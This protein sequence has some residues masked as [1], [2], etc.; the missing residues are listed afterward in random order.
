MAGDSDSKTVFVAVGLCLVCSMV[1]SVLAVV[2][3][4]IQAEQRE[5]FRKQSIL[6]AAGIW[7]DGADANKLF[8]R[9]REIKLDL[10]DHI[11]MDGDASDPKYDRAKSLR[12]EDLHVVL[13]QADDPAGL[14][15][16][17]K[18]VIIYEVSNDDDEGESQTTRLV[19]PIRGRGLW[20]T[21]YGFIAVDVGNGLG[22]ESV[23]VVGITYYKHGETPGLG[24]E[25]ENPLWK[26][27]WPG[28]K[29]YDQDWK[30]VV[31]VAKNAPQDSPTQVDAISGATLTSNG[32]TNMLQFWLGKKGFGPYVRQ[33]ADGS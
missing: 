5:L 3:R 16:L 15:K 20:S 33:I 29:V 22:P 19:L 21:L 30:V 24:G 25:V 27:K 10:E 18:N 32:V 28:K 6:D 12:D 26:N 2:L 17:E 7:R 9:V 4:P 23:T 1:V 31:E 14:K 13:E 8:G 11:E